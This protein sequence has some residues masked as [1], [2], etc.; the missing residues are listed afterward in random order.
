MSKCCENMER[1]GFIRKYANDKD[2]LAVRG[3]VLMYCQGDKQD[4]CKRK[5]YKMRTGNPPPDEML[6]SGTMMNH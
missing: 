6:P 5:E 2:G 1:C 4:C 3:F